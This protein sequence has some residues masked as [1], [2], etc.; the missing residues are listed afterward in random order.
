MGS[1]E[2]EQEQTSQAAE[3]GASANSGDTGERLTALEHA[4]DRIEHAVERLV[5]GSHAEA[6]QR[7]ERR[8]DRGSSM[9]EA[10]RAALAEAREQEQRDQAAAAAAES[11]TAERRQVQERLAALEERPPAPPRLRRT[12]LLGWGDGRS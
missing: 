2:Q 7:T 9:A 5:P 1:Q 3:P 10:A 4:V 12:V 8:L 11:Q 6:E